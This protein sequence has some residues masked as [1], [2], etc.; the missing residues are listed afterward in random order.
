MK[1]SRP[2]EYRTILLLTDFSAPSEGAR[3]EAIALARKHGARLLILHV[4]ETTSFQDVDRDLAPFYETLLRRAE[5]E[6][7]RT[8]PSSLT[9][10]LDVERALRT[11]RP[12]S[13]ILALIAERG[14]DL[15]VMGSH[16]ISGM[17]RSPFGSTAYK[18]SLA[19][20]CPVLIV[21][22]PAFSPPQP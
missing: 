18:V 11:G 16:G 1:A 13:E 20:P 8:F 7:E 22:P 6:L 9:E 15:V 21:K 12:V 17:A 19:A 2:G 4:V 10:G 5:R 3:D 14:V